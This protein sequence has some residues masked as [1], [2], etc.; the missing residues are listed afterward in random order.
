MSTVNNMH[1]Y[2]GIIELNG[3]SD[4]DTYL[5]NEGSAGSDWSNFCEKCSVR[6]KYN[7]YLIETHNK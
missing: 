5:S 1:S 7:G 3:G 6:D 2:L 4:I